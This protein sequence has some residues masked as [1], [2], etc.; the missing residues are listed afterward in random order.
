MKIIKTTAIT[1]GLTALSFSA[2]AQEED[3]GPLAFTYATYFTCTGDYS[4]ADD[5]MAGDAERMN[6][7][8]EDGTIVSH[9]WLKHHTGGNWTRARYYQHETLEGLL[10]AYDVINDTGDD[11]DDDNAG[12]FADVCWGHEDYIWSLDNGS[13]SDSR[14]KAGFSVYF[15]CDIGREER[16][17]EIVDEH[18]APILNAY[19]EDGKLA[20]WGWSTHVVGGHVRALQ[21]MTASDVQS[22]IEARSQSIADIYAENNE[23]GMEFAEICGD[24]EDYIWNID[25]EN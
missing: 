6:G 8:V 25:L 4:V 5:I 17:G 7:L 9:G 16:A 11:D 13:N 24:H 12:A 20:S 19:V 14:G 22:L 3:E 10:N 21:T 23:A 1:L 2:F 18:I 15:Q